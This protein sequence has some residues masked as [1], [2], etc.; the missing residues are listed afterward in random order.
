MLFNYLDSLPKLYTRYDFNFQCNTVLILT[1]FFCLFSSIFGKTME[2]LRKRVNI[3]LVT[4]ARKLKK[5]VSKPNLKTSKIFNRGLAGVSR[6]NTTIELNRPVYVGTSIL[7][8]SKL[9]MY[10]YHYGYIRPTYGDSAKLL[11]TDTDSFCYRITTPDVYRDME[12]KRSELFD[13]SSYPRDHFLYDQTNC[14][15]LGKFKDEADGVP[16]EAFC[17]LRSKMYSLKYGDRCK[18]TAKGVAK[19]VVRK[20]VT[21]QDYVDALFGETTQMAT[22]KTIRSFNHNL[23]TVELTKASLNPF[24]SKRYVLPDRVSTLAYGHRDIRLR[25]D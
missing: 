22:F 11:F 18:K 25:D 19:H 5:L 23:K 6:T 15:V 10:D 17:G 9:T 2:N 14:K 3:Q 24:D 20:H 4:D 13:F 16:I 12:K 21:H 1:R 8:V 7:D